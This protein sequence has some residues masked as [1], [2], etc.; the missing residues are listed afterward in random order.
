L[1]IFKGYFFAFSALWAYPGNA[2]PF[3]SSHSVDR[4]RFSD[5][6]HR[7]LEFPQGLR[8]G[9]SNSF[10]DKHGDQDTWRV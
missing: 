2:I 3:P 1:S 5:R 8:R 4:L 6:R 7:R 9:A 10:T